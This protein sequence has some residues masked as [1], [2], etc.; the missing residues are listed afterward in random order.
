MRP[1]APCA[2]SQMVMAITDMI[3]DDT[4]GY[5]FSGHSAGSLSTRPLATSKRA[6]WSGHSIAPILQPAIRQDGKG[7]GADI[8]GDME[9][10]FDII[11]HEAEF[12]DIQADHLA[13]RQAVAW[14]QMDPIVVAQTDVFSGSIA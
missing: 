8:V 7:M 4:T 14:Q 11:D 2:S 3:V 5:V 1:S 10:A 9:I 12:A 6:P 13:L